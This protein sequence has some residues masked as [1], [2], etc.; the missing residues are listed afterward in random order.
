MN[1]V[2][3]AAVLVAVPVLAHR[4]LLRPDAIVAG[5][6][7]AEVVEELLTKVPVPQAETRG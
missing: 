3:Q 2:G 6:S 4:V 7:S 1:L 5:T